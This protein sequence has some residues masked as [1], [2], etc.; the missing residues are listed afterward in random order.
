MKA[1]KQKKKQEVKVHTSRMWDRAED[2]A[3]DRQETQLNSK[4][5]EIGLILLVEYELKVAGKSL[6]RGRI[7]IS[8]GNEKVR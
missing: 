3:N 4:K 2:L 1:V 5:W 7:L 6:C 8:A